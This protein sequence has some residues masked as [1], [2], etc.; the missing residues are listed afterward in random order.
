[1]YTDTGKLLNYRQ[2]MRNTKYKNNWRTPSENEFGGLAN[3]VDGH[4][5]NGTNTIAFIRRNEIPHY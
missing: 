3:G 4:I 2:L 5:K 1:M